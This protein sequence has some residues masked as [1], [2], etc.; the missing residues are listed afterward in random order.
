VIASVAES[1]DSGGLRRPP[2][3]VTLPFAP[4]PASRALESLYYPSV[5]TVVAAVRG[6]LG[7]S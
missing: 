6:M 1:P 5:E 7:R 2:G 4:A 3:R